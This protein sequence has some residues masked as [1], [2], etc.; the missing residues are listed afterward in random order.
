MGRQ[1][2]SLCVELHANFLEKSNL[3]WAEIQIEK[4]AITDSEIFYMIV[5]SVL[6]VIV[7]IMYA[8]GT[9]FLFAKRRN[10]YARNDES[11]TQETDPRKILLDW[12]PQ[13]YTDSC[14]LTNFSELMVMLFKI[15]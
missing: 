2:G 11:L 12:L 1:V 6:I 15:P 9:C 7:M 3:T 4:Q 13:S 10:R 14:V 5:A 8:I